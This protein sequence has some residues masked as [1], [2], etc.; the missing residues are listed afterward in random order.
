MN[1][2]EYILSKQVQWAR[3]N[4]ITLVGSKGKRGRLAY[5]SRLGDNLFQPLEPAVRKSFEAGDGGELAGNPSKMC[6]IHSSSALGVNIF[7]YWLKAKQI[8]IIAAACGF[9]SKNNN[10]SYNIKVE[11]KFPIDYQFSH[12]PNIDVIIENSDESKFKVFAVECKFSEA[13]FSQGH[14]G[15]KQKYI[16]L[17]ELWDTMPHLYNFAKSISPEDSKFRH[18]HP[19][20][21]VK[22]ILGL[23]KNVGRN[24]FRLLYLWYDCIGHEGARHSDEIEEFSHVTTKDDIHFHA[25]S[26][27]DLIVKLA[28][29]CR[30][31]HENYI[32]YISSRYL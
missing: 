15:L 13:Y 11:Q 18:L 28:N 30:A 12:S 5:T 17:D 2:F 6:A 8:P 23:T 26:Y 4:K 31:S 27:Q 32:K 10:Y 24:K 9:C 25:L 22:H 1:A 16:K 20:Q 21:L 19:A 7:Q 29:E 14:A 3:N